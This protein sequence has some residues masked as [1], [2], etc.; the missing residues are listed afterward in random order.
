MLS[1]HKFGQS[2]WDALGYV[3]DASEQPPL[4]TMYAVRRVVDR[5]RLG[6]ASTLQLAKDMAEKDAA[7]T[8]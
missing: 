3:I 1:W 2:Q 6:S 4:G 7:K 8:A 5:T